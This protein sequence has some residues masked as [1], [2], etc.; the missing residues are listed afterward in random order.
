M[1]KE[2]FGG[3][4]F[5]YS[6]CSKLRYTTRFGIE[7]VEKMVD[8]C[9]ENVPPTP[10][11][12]ILEVG[13]GNGTLLLGLLDAGYSA[14]TLHGIDYSEAAV[15]L[16]KAV[17]GARNGSQINYHLCD[18]LHEDP[19]RP[20]DS[21][22][23]WDLVLD[24]GTLD[25]ISLSKKDENNLSPVSLYPGRVVR[26]LKPNGIFLITCERTMFRFHNRF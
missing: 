26:L 16:S 20:N 7:T 18:F 24:K 5:T 2:K 9:S 25:A 22:S 14:E 4:Y 12:R 1:R 11:Q 19:L 6:T 13:C 3:Q 21:G 10:T 8:W 23:S 15:N 17:A